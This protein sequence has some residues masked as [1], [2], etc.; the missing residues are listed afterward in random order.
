MKENL[1]RKKE[2]VLNDPNKWE[3]N[4][5]EEFRMSRINTGKNEQRRCI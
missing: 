3:L 1:I 5:K 2:K 4:E